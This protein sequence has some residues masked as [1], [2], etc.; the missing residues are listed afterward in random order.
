MSNA[1]LDY[2]ETAAELYFS[3]QYGEL[4]EQAEARGALPTPPEAWLLILVAALRLDRYRGTGM[5]PP[6]G[7]ILESASRHDPLLCGLLSLAQGK[8]TLESALARG[9]G[10]DHR[11]RCFFYAAANLQT[12]DEWVGAVEAF[13]ECLRAG[14]PVPERSWAARALRGQARLYEIAPSPSEHHGAPRLLW[15]ARQPMRRGDMAAARAAFATAEAK[16]AAFPRAPALPYVWLLSDLAA[17]A[18]GLGWSDKAAEPLRTALDA[19]A[20][21]EARYPGTALGLIFKYNAVVPPGPNPTHAPYLERAVALQRAVDDDPEEVASW[22]EAFAARAP[23]ERRGAAIAAL[24]EA[25]SLREGEQGGRPE[26]YRARRFLVQCLL[27][28]EDHAAALPEALRLVASPARELGAPADW[29][30]QDLAFALHLAE[31]PAGA[32]LREEDL[33]LLQEAAARAEGDPHARDRIRY[34][35]ATLLQRRGGHWSAIEALRALAKSF[36]DG[37]DR[38]AVFFALATSYRE[39]GESALAAEAVR[40]CKRM[41]AAAGPSQEQAFN[42]AILEAE[43]AFNAGDEAGGE[44]ALRSAGDLRGDDLRRRLAY[45]NVVTGYYGPRGNYAVLA[46]LLADLVPRP[47]ESVQFADDLPA[48]L[49]NTALAAMSVGDLD[50]AKQLFA[51]APGADSAGRPSPHA[52]AALLKNYAKLCVLQDRP[53]EGVH[54]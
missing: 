10:L 52:P 40:E 48:L 23:A 41:L 1:S 33:D 11:C 47:G 6:L 25:I 16:L 36:P 38:L 28:A 32:G 37:E 50:K 45:L 20:P 43:I 26:L 31:G 54:C 24:R 5:G 27:Q 9:G 35:I 18:A 15:E 53:G 2:L 3:G 21:D 7:H 14:A 29:P 8:M 46:P 34:R 13:E 19:L 22:L 49:N 51:Q 12:N 42:V 30:L 44:A 17:L 4:V 39:V